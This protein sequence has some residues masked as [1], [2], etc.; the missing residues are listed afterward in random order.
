MKNVP[1]LLVTVVATPVQETKPQTPG[2]IRTEVHIAFCSMVVIVDQF[3]HKIRTK[4]LWLVD[5]LS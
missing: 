3:G 2:L 4:I 5:F 1:I